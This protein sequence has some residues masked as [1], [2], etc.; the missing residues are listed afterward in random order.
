MFLPDT[1]MEYFVVRRSHSHGCQLSG[2][3]KSLLRARRK[4]IPA[5]QKAL[6]ATR[7]RPKTA[8]WGIVLTAITID[9]DLGR[10]KSTSSS[11]GFSK[12]RPEAD[13]QL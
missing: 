10:L 2:Q 3:S 12:L 8:Q 4:A 7:S 11:N 1:D 13:M 5:A 6:K 9:L